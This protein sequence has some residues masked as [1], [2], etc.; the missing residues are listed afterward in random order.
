MPTKIEARQ[1]TTAHIGYGI[2]FGHDAGLTITDIG[3]GYEGNVKIGLRG[4]RS[5]NFV[6]EVHPTHLLTITQKES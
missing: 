5:G 3:P 2:Q 6:T 4:P 1:L